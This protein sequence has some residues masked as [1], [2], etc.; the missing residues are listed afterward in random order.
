MT[1]PE[2]TYDAWWSEE[3]PDGSG[4][5]EIESDCDEV[6]TDSYEDKDLY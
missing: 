6:L 3:H 1:T 5:C 4:S 2:D